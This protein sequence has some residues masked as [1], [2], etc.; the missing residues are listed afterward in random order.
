MSAPPTLERARVA[1][2]EPATQAHHG[3][4]RRA[5]LRIRR[6]VQE[7]NYANRRLMEVQAPW[8]V[9]AQWHRR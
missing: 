9:D 3:W 4:L 8:S 7:M 6:T 1:A 5:W 2:A